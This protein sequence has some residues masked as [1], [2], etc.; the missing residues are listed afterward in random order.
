MAKSIFTTFIITGFAFSLFFGFTGVQIAHEGM[1]EGS[2]CIASLLRGTSC[3]AFV[4]VAASVAFH[5]GG[6]K[7][8]STA[9]IQG[10]FL[11]FLLAFVAFGLAT[12]RKVF[13]LPVP[14]ISFA[15]RLPLCYQSAVQKRL[16]HWFSLKLHSPP[17]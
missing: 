9:T 7:L 4:D 13:F 11:L 6:L 1:A 17:F 16:L 12:A 5:L 3:P 8:L 15:A 10:A 14:P 2:A